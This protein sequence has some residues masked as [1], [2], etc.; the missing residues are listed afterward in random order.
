[1]GCSS[2]QGGP[3]ARLLLGLSRGRSLLGLHSCEPG[4]DTTLGGGGH[5]LFPLRI[6]RALPRG[7]AS[8]RPRGGAPAL[9]GARPRVP[10]SQWQR[11][12]RPRP[13]RSANRNLLLCCGGAAAARGRQ[14]PGGSGAGGSLAGA[15]GAAPAGPGTVRGAGGPGAAVGC[16]GFLSAP[17]GERGPGGKKPLV[18]GP[19]KIWARRR[20][21]VGPSGSTAWAPAGASRRWRP[22]SAARISMES[23]WM[24]GGVG[25]QNVCPEIR[26]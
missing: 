5:D 8:P 12:G 26:Q 11:P 23:R 16:G 19:L 3:R 4:C 18:P 17:A 21:L 13:P 22:A 1:M 15:G 2:C 14:R 9:C 20:S 25:V 7:S 6:S 10:R 24:C